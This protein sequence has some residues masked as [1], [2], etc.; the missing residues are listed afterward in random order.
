MTLFGAFRGQALFARALRGSA[1]TAGSY[2][3]AQGLRLASNLVLA[4]L[5]FPEAFGLMALV[6]VVL[7]GLTMFSDVGIGPA[8][9]RSPRGDDPD[10]LNTAWSLQVLRGGILWLA[11][12]GLG[13]LLAWAYQAPDLSVLIP[14]AGLSLLIAGFNPTRIDSASRHLMLGRVTALDLAAQ[15]IGIAAMVLFAALSGSVWALV[16]GAVLT[17]LAKLI[18]MHHFLPGAANRFRWEPAAGRELVHFGKWIFLST[19]C[20]FVMAQGD[21]LILGAYLPIDRLG[22][23]NIG[24]FLASFPWLLGGAVV[25]KV[26]I[27]L[28][29]DDPPGAKAANAPRLRRMRM[30][31]T[32]GLLG[33]LGVL[34][35]I[36]VPLVGLLYDDRYT[37]AGAVVVL[38][39][40]LQMPAVIGMTYDQA[41]LAAGDSRNFFFVLLA[42]ALIQT[43]AFILGAE[44]GGLVGALAGQGLALAAMH[45]LVIWLARRH[46]VWDPRHDLL[47]SGVALTLILAALALHR[48]EIAAL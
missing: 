39:A 25:M 30:A 20:G 26:M 17:A 15:T 2:A 10:F 4:R 5:L 18:L 29:R 42:K 40:C 12:L 44:L 11:T 31:M 19:A 6:T 13:P 21:R 16:L 36:G 48:A 1:F 27:P 45:P 23:Y 14:V 8:I 47:W 35:L 38:V 24:Y 46:Q 43:F 22:V 3:L 34:A 9:S 7:V 33:L 28:Y 37:M 32:G 41:A